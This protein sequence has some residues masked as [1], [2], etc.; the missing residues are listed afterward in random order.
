MSSAGGSLKSTSRSFE[1]S[2][3]IKHAKV[4]LTVSASAMDPRRM[5]K[6]IMPAI[7]QNMTTMISAS[8]WGV[9]SPYPIDSI[10]TSIQYAPPSHLIRQHMDTNQ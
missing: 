10:V 7:M 3:D 9:M 2:Y 5:P 8:V 1:S 6:K 4:A